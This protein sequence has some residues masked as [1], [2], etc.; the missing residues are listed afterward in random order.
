MKGP[1]DWEDPADSPLVRHVLYT[2]DV[3]GL[4]T[5]IISGLMYRCRPERLKAALEHILENWDGHVA[6]CRRVAEHEAAEK[7]EPSGWED[8]ER[9]R[10]QA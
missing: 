5:A 8:A 2:N 10:G 4:L 3:L 9:T 6:A 7:G 1:T